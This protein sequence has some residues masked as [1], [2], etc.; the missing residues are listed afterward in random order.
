MNV[1]TPMNDNA[2]DDRFNRG[3]ERLL[4]GDPT[5][6]DEIDPDLQDVAIQ[7]VHLANDA[8]WIG[9]EPGTEP[10]RPHAWWRNTR[11]V[12]N[13]MAAVLVIGLVAVMVTVGLRVWAPA[14]DQYGAG[15]T[16]DDM[17]LNQPAECRRA[18]RT[19][20]EIA[21]IVR[22]SAARVEPFRSDGT[23]D[24]NPSTG[25][26]GVLRDWNT[27]LQQ[28]NWHGAMAYESEFFIWLLGQEVFPDGV[29][30]LTDAEI[31]AGV[32]ERHAQI[33]PINT[34]NGT[35]L[36]I[37]HIDTF[38][39]SFSSNGAFLRGADV[40]LVPLDSD[41]NWLE[42]PAVVSVEWN[43][44]QWMMV[45]INRDGVPDSEYFRH[46]ALPDP[47]GTPSP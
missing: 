23:Q 3:L 9:T 36:S 13:A 38:R 5:G 35:N 14:N 42:W 47:V 1:P 11:T 8:G 25:A 15:P 27:C 31:S 37:Y 6:I 41:G 34:S 40:W 46:D 28:Q 4:D 17:F 21:G 24:Q 12:V 33:E 39:Q 26:I 30:N 10:I 43:G 29:A 19:D 20:A 7:M 44:E 32:A 18:P 16:P 22:K 45:T 2:R